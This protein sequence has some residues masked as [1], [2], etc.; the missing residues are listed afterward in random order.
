[1]VTPVDTTGPL[2][3]AYTQPPLRIDDD[4]DVQPSKGPKNPINTTADLIDNYFDENLTDVLRASTVGS[5]F[6]AYL[7]PT[8]DKDIILH[9]C[10]RWY[11]RQQPVANF[12]SPGGGVG[13]MIVALL[14]LLPFYNTT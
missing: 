12:K 8:N 11:H 13:A 10:P 4:L 2:N 7:L 9:V 6:S 3:L 14:Q 5:N 1:M